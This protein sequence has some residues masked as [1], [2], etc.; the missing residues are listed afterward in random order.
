[1]IVD[2]CVLM[3]KCLWLECTVSVAVHSSCRLWWHRNL[4][5]QHCGI[6]A[7]T[8]K[9]THRQH[10]QTM[11]TDRDDTHTETMP[12]PTHSVVVSWVFLGID[13][14]SW[15][16]RR[17]DGQAVTFS[18]W[19]FAGQTVYYNTHQVDN[20]KWVLDIWKGSHYW[21]LSGVLGM[22]HEH[23]T[24]RCFMCVPSTAVAKAAEL[25]LLLELVIFGEP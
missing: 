23:L 10:T 19:D 15:Q 1:M 18:V 13:I 3:W 12:M 2:G 22:L 6:Y 11:H 17:P 25:S 7:Y 24:E 20:C 16:L 14:S 21:S 9:H 8:H 4:V 5:Q